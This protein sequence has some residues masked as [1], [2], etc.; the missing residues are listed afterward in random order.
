MDTLIRFTFDYILNIMVTA[1]LSSLSELMK[2]VLKLLTAR[3]NIAA[4]HAE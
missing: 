3:S 1:E 2:S 4:Q